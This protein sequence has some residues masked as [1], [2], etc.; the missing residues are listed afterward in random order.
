M[1]STATPFG[2]RVAKHITADARPHAIDGGI[3]TGYGSTIYFGAPVTLSTDGTLNVATVTSKLCGIFAGVRYAPNATDMYTV[4]QQWTSG[5][6]YVAGSCTAYIF[7]FDDPGLIYEIQCATSLA[8]TSVGDQ[9]NSVNPTSGTGQFSLCSLSGGLAGAGNTGQFRI[10]DVVGRP[11]NA[12]GDAFTN[13][14]VQIAAHQFYPQ[15]TA[16]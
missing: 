1:S 5:Q 7:G 13:V 10:L 15:A 3:V 2:L 6:S 4:Q 14:Y 8:A 16:I 11:G 12:W 9:A